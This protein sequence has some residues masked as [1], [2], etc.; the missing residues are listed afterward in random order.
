MKFGNLI[1][2]ERLTRRVT[3]TDLAHRMGIDKALM[4]KIENGQ[5]LATKDQVKKLIE[6][7]KLDGPKF[8]SLW[9]SDKILYEIRD[10]A[11][12]LEALRIAEEEIQYQMLD[13]KAFR[14]DSSL[15]KML[16]ELDE[17]KTE[18]QNKKPLNKIQLSK[19]KEHYNLLYTCES[20]KIEGNTLTLK[21][22]FLV[23]KEGLTIGGKTV[24][25]HL[26]AINHSDATD[27]LSELVSSG[28]DFS[29]RI[30]K[31]LHYLILKGIDRENAGA[32]RKVPV[33]IGGS[34]FVPP[35]PFLISKLMEDVFYYYQVNKDKIHPVLMA[36]DLHEKIVTIHP[37]ID[38][39]GRTC[40]LVMNLILLANGYTICVLKG[41]QRSRMKYYSALEKVQLKNDRQ[42]FYKLVVQGCI[43]SVKEH[44]NMS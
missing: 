33:Y 39:N 40:R 15:Q 37:F 10:E 1:K 19:M 36:A 38:G 6:E 9:L 13:G 30:L 26:E 18:W 25:E 8:L 14:P 27:Y 42:A 16:D 11:Y 32:Y 44:I 12:A 35:Q 17:L 28:E 43:H 2:A 34:N 5:R 20:N 24:N 31:E 22:T 41:D 29:E 3:M 21:E 7:L 4:S 23:V